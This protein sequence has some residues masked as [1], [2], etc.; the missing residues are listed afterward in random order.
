M[1]A[2]DS[3]DRH[4]RT[5]ILIRPYVAR[6]HQAGE[7]APGVTEDEAVEWAA[8]VLLLIPTMPG[9]SNLDIT[10]PRSFGRT[11]A[12][13]ICQRIGRPQPSAGHGTAGVQAKRAR[14]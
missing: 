1:P 9:S 7:L 2:V 6:A 13:R 10:D 14:H 4:E 12:R 3:R 8:L 11:L 5:S